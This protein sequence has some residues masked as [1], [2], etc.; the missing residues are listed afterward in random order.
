MSDDTVTFPLLDARLDHFIAIGD[1]H[2]WGR[3]KSE[4]KA[5]ARMNQEGGKAKRFVIY[6]ATGATYVNEMG[7]L[8][9]PQADPAPVLLRKH[10]A[11]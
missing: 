6:R 5:I 10:P 4:R 1:N 3:D 7:D 11:A 9:R 8:V 2:G